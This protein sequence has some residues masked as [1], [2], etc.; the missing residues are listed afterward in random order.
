M[1]GRAVMNPKDICA[2]VDATDS[3]GIRTRLADYAVCTTNTFTNR[4]KLFK[5]CV[6]LILEGK[7]IYLDSNT[8]PKHF[9]EVKRRKN[10]KINASRFRR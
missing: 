5:G 2:K 7:K 10:V 3:V 9:Y 4:M 8:K 1:A 6:A